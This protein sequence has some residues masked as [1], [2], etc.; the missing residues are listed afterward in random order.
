MEE[1]KQ[2]VKESGKKCKVIKTENKTLNLNKIK[3]QIFSCQL[4][5]ERTQD[6]TFAV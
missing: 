1:G 4:S 3:T 2:D 6:H 5:P